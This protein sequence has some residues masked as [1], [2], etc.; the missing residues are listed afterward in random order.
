MKGKMKEKMKRDKDE[1][2]EVFF[3]VKNVS[4]PSNPPDKLAQNVSNKIPLGR[5]ILPFFLRKF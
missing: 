3:F 5:I 2:K 4:E 1:R